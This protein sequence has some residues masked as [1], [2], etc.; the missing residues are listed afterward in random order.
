MKKLKGALIG[1]GAI[2]RE[3]LAAVQELNDVE[4]AAVCDISA[5]RA[6]ATAERFGIAH[7]YT[8]HDQMLSEHQPIWSI[9][10]RRPPATFHSRRTVFREGLTFYARNPSP[11][12]MNSSNF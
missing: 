7:W 11:P 4:M 8:S 9:S 12:N 1:C 6:E 2:A 10:R 5:A 3:H